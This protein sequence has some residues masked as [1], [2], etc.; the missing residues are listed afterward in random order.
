LRWSDLGCALQKLI[1][2]IAIHRQSPD[3]GQRRYLI[4][5]RLLRVLSQ[6][7][8]CHIRQH[9]LTKAPTVSDFSMSDSTTL[10]DQSSS[11]YCLRPLN[12][13]F[14]NTLRQKLLPSRSEGSLVT[15]P[16]TFWIILRQE[17][18]WK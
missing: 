1:D 4:D 9:S 6:T 12:V 11:G 7:Y 8:K 13:T 18:M 16:N 2:I 14:N 17:K 5:Y 3:L 10:S 15:S